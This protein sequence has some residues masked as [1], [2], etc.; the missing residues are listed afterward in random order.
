[1]MEDKLKSEYFNSF[2]TY[3]YVSYIKQTNKSP[4]S[5]VQPF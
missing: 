4:P 1:M 5:T 3:H 2:Y